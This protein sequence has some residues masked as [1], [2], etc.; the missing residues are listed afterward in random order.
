MYFL[1]V[2]IS[3]LF[4]FDKMTARFR[5]LQYKEKQP[6]KNRQGKTFEFLKTTKK[7]SFPSL[8][9][10]INVELPN[11]LKIKGDILISR[12]FRVVQKSSE[13]MNQNFAFTSQM[14]LYEGECTSV[15]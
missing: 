7:D 5:F 11:K 1:S 14:K 4:R 13:K 2:R 8:V 6:S 9:L 15:F 12:T 3:I 10:L